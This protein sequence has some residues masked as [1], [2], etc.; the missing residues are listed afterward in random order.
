MSR[1][2]HVYVL[3]CRGNYLY[4]GYTVDVKRRLAQHNKGIGSRFTRS[5][6]PVKLVY[7]E[8]FASR[9]TALK[10]ELQIKRLS[11]RRKLILI[12]KRRHTPSSTDRSEVVESI[13]SD[14]NTLIELL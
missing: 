13:T 9:S 10:R 4:T 8:S 3:S 11:H 12:T 1:R 14:V 2:H 5:H 6:L 7:S